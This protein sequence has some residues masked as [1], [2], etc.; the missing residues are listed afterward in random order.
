[1]GGRAI[2]RRRFLGGLAAAGLAVAGAGAWLARRANPPPVL[3]SPRDI[4]ADVRAEYLRAWDAYKRLA[5]GHDELKPVSGSYQEFFVKGHPVGLTIVEA[6]DTL[7]VMALDDELDLCVRWIEGSLNLDIDAPFQVF[8][9][10]IRMLGG[11][12]A[13]HLATKNEVLL[14]KAK[15]LADRLLP[16]FTK[17]PTGMPYRFVNLH[18]G[19]VSK[20]A[21]FVAEIGTNLS[22]F[23][24]L[25]KL[26]GDDRYYQIAKRAAQAVFERRS[27]LDLIATTIDIESGRWLS[28]VSVGPQPPVDSYYEYLLDGY[29]LFDDPD[30][31]TWFKTLTAALQR[32]QWN[33]QGGHFWYQQVE[34][35]TGT[36][37]NNRESELAAFWAGNLAEAGMTKEADQFLDSFKSVLDRYCLFP[38][39]WDYT[40]MSILDPAYQLRPE[41]ADSCLA[42][43]VASGGSQLYRQRAYQLYESMKANCRVE[44]GYT[45]VNDITTRPMT[46]GDLTPGYWFSENMKYFYLLFSNT[47]RFDYHHNYLTTEGKVLVGL[48]PPAT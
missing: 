10:I 40:D 12:L 5:W 37:V 30:L 8:E 34:F 14:T 45:I 13:G 19:A 23:G 24:M 41:Y 39:Q 38:E 43:F 48:Q 6:L 16:A 27:T 17:S 21:N 7:Y 36:L 35:Q 3:P 44:N 47:P 25:S 29:H 28:A 11:L 42:L 15:E 2:S 33:A 22:E 20:P 26:T 31:L 32:R 9:T 18:S 1:M 4:A 46:L